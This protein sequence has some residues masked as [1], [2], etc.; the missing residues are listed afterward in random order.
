MKE[1]S[2][3]IGPRNLYIADWHYG[4]AN[5]IGH[6]NRPFQT[7]AEMN[8]AFV[9]RWNDAVRPEDTVYILG[10]MFWCCA[11]EAVGVLRT[12]NGKKVLIKGDHDGN[13]KDSKFCKE[14]KQI[15]DYHLEIEDGWQYVV[16]CHYPIPCFRLHFRKDWCHLYGHV[17]N[18]FEWNMMERFKTAMEEL[19]HNFEMYNVGA[20]MPWM[21]Y[22]PKTLY[23]IS[24][25]AESF[26]WKKGVNVYDSSFDDRRH[27]TLS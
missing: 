16:L 24:L 18:T 1:R 15:R 22:T 26:N 4:H 20:M 2:I 23:E 13:T 17:H 9:I 21:D 12:L 6:D 7:L 27:Q 3:H 5:V 11:R 25:G 19:G 8:E 10:D 14:F